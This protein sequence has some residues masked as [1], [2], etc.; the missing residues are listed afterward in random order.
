MGM[1][2]IS[3]QGGGNCCGNLRENGHKAHTHTTANYAASLSQITVYYV[4]VHDGRVSS[5]GSYSRE[6]HRKRVGKR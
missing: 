1:R 6:R 4:S 5:Q 2:G 3:C